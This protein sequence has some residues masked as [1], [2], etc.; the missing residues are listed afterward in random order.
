MRKW[1][2][3]IFLRKMLV[4]AIPIIIQNGITNFVGMLDNIMVG[5][6]GT[7]QMSAVSISNQLIFVYNLCIFGALSGAGIFT[8]QYFGKQDKEGIR[9]SIRYKWLISIIVTILSLLIFGFFGKTLI[10]YYL[11]G[12][13]NISDT[14]FYGQEY[15][16]IMMIGMPLYM[17]AQIYSNTLR[18]TSNTIIPMRSGIVAITVN[19]IGNYILIYGKFGFSKLGC[20]GAAYATV[21]SRLVEALCNVIWVHTHKEKCDY[22]KDVYTSFYIPL[23]QIKTYFLTGTPLLLNETMWAAGMAMLIQCYSLRGLHVVA[24]LNIAN[25]IINVSNTVFLALGVSVGII[26]G[27][28]LGAQC[29]QEAKDTEKK[30]SLFSVLSVIPIMI[31]V[32]FIAPV[33]PKIY[34][35]TTE[36]QHLATTIILISTLFMPL[37]SYIN[38]IYFIM[39][40]GGRTMVA[41]LFDSIFVWSVS[42]TVAFILSR[43]TNLPVHMIFLSVQL[44]DLVKM[45]VGTILIK[46]GIWIQDITT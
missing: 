6:I 4:I 36:I 33:F 1:F 5:R 14:L 26:V 8:A 11:N 42:V 41:F 12:Q 23:S 45:I 40:A 9:Y 29:V 22:M 16:H 38:C 13:G 37:Q 10:S 21:L 31:L 46:K 3:K 2:D 7:E 30:A 44:L 32:F 17:I 18:E 35:T 15:L 24:G 27:Q 25:T 34:N 43:F 19:L 20:V 39:R 28:L